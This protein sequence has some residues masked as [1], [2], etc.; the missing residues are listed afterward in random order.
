[1]NNQI[2]E[3][4]TGDFDLSLGRMRIMNMARILEV[5]KSMRLHGQLQPVVARMHKGGIQLI[6]GYKRLYAAENLLM[7]G[8]QC[9]LLEVD[10][11]QAKVLMLSYNWSS[12]SLES[13]EEALVLKDLL[14]NHTMDQRELSR[15][16]GKS[17]SWVSR[18]LGLIERL[19][20]EIGTEIRM[21]SLTGSHARALMR[22]PR[23]NQL[24]VARVIQTHKLT[25][26]QSE[27]L[28]E[29]YL[30]AE[31]ERS[32]QVLLRA[33]ERVL[34]SN[35]VN[36]LPAQMY[37]PRLSGYAN[38]VA[39]SINGVI[40]SLQELLKLLEDHRASSLQQ[41]ERMLLFPGLEII[42]DGLVTLKQAMGQ[43]QI[44]K[45]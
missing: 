35:N 44:H 2:K 13:Y 12:R 9:R 18:R 24:T 31:D 20:E 43:L 15:L 32:Q 16:T 39:R 22:L 30:A 17:V 1:V 41:S 7:E 23:G 33:P 38:E 21:G 29:A 4:S 40:A 5:E 28:V 10:E 34:Y 25:S 14:E 11:H 19:D 6:D 45:T 42:A 26:R 3:I 8:L 37:D 36:A 27:R